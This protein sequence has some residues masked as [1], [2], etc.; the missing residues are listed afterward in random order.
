VSPTT[1]SSN[2]PTAGQYF[3]G[4]SDGSNVAGGQDS[5]VL[6]GDGNEACDT[7]TGIGT[8]QGNII[9][10]GS[11]P[12]YNANSFIGGGGSNVITSPYTFLGAGY[13]NEATNREAF[14]G[15]G[16]YG[17]A[18][19]LGS[20]VGAGGDAYYYDAGEAAFPGDGDIA[21]G[22]DSFVGAG[23]LNQITPGGSGSFIG[24]GD[25]TYASTGATKPGNQIS[26]FDSFI[27]AGDQNVVSALE[28]FV[29]SG[30]GNVIG[31]AGSYA[32][33][34]GGN[35]NSVSAEYA[36]IIGG[37]GN[38]ASG[39]YAIVAG[40]DSDTAAGTVSFAAGYHADAAH[41]GSFVWSDYHSGSATVK[42]SA[43]NQFIVR[44][45]GGTYVYSNETATAGVVLT[46]GSGTW[47]NSSD[48]NAKTDVVPLDDA[49]ILAKVAA[50]P[51]AG[52]SYKSER[53]V[54]HV[55]PMAQDFYAAFGT[56]IDDRHI[57]SIDEDGVALVAIKGLDAKLASKDG[58]ID[59]L[60]RENRQVESRLVAV[61]AR[62][63]ALGRR[64]DALASRL[65]E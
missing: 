57:T 30:G 18:E 45:S 21:A 4:V 35:R 36:S 38:T 1:C 41:N 3:L 16:T 20:F 31:S 54:R 50:L 9:G 15:A 40:G 53:G 37:Y 25:F 32:S 6:S 39:S 10:A 49:S 13:G 17:A 28:A 12:G 43:I 24:G 62:N 55:G 29:G 51:I 22:T 26:G 27:G 44:A 59:K 14:V 60:E 33:I 23:D 34:I 8:G 52:W 64:L 5:A 42:D 65:P 47:A 56:G 63:A 58:E 46:P 19:G 7:Y 2:Y 11:S 61:E 48:R